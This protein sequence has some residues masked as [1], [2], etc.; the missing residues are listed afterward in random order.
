VDALEYELD[1]LYKCP[2]LSNEQIEEF[3]SAISNEIDKAEIDN[4]PSFEPQY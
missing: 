1:K 2:L 4:N 3:R